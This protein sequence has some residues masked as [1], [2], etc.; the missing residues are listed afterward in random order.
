MKRNET[1]FMYKKKLP[2][3]E[4]VN[5]N[6]K[7]FDHFVSTEDR[8][9]KNIT[10]AHFNKY[11]NDYTKTLKYPSSNYFSTEKLK[12]SIPFNYLSNINLNKNLNFLSTL[13]VFNFDKKA[14]MFKTNI[15]NNNSPNKIKLISY[16]NYE[17]Q[18][19]NFAIEDLG[20]A[21]NSAETIHF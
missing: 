5:N 2:K 9:V 4:I 10:L 19:I 6:A 16:S 21:T 3:I 11:I 20:D 12:H 18:N 14:G 15:N 13:N 8:K 7:K 1:D 17:T